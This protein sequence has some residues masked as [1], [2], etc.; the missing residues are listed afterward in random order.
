MN[1]AKPA[2]INKPIFSITAQDAAALLMLSV[3]IS[4]IIES[5]TVDTDTLEEL[6]LL[7]PGLDNIVYRTEE[8]PLYS[9]PTKA[10]V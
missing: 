10:R 2:M 4:K 3:S 6:E 5:R 1:E 9:Q 7:L 8:K